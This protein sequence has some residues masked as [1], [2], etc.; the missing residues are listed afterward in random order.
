[1]TAREDNG[2]TYGGL[3]TAE[4]K[5]DEG[6]VHQLVLS[7]LDPLTALTEVLPKIE[8]LARADFLDLVLDGAIFKMLDGENN[9]RADVDAVDLA[10]SRVADAMLTSGDSKLVMLL[11]QECT[12]D[13]HAL[14]EVEVRSVYRRNLGELRRTLE[15]VLRRN[16]ADF[17]ATR[18][19]ELRTWGA[20]AMEAAVGRLRPVFKPESIAAAIRGFSGFRSSPESLPGQKSDTAGP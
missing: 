4:V 19:T 18:A 14:N 7:D 10:L 11:L 8:K 2:R 17:F 1:V 5:D 12:R 13:D 15:I 16:F 3:P 9:A 20:R 6:R